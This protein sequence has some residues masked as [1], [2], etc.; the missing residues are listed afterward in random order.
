MRLLAVEYTRRLCWRDGFWHLRA[1]LREEK[2]E[3]KSEGERK[4]ENN[5]ILLSFARRATT[6]QKH[7]LPRLERKEE[8]TIRFFCSPP[9][10]SRE[11]ERN[12]GE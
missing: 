6:K 4:E 7:F 2:R 11:V 8:K 12:R 3:E 1:R 5:D 10:D 9:C